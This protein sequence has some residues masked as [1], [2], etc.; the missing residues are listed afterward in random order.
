[1]SGF[2]HYEKEVADLDHEIRRYAAICGVN[3]DSRAEVEACM[4]DHR[5]ESARESLRGLLVLRLK[6]ETEMLELGMRPP[7]LGQIGG[8]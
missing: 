6:L 3:L 7:S 4:A 2:E 1:M 5:A 8:E